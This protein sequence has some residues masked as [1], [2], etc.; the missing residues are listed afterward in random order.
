VTTR[1]ELAAYPHLVIL[2]RAGALAEWM[3]KKRE[4]EKG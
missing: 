2:P 1:E 3:T 4:P